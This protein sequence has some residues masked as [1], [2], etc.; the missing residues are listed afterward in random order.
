M[1]RGFEKNR[2]ILLSVGVDFVPTSGRLCT[3]ETSR[4]RH[5]HPTTRIESRQMLQQPIMCSASNPIS[6]DTSH[7]LAN[8]ASSSNQDSHGD[9]ENSHENGGKRSS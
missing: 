9:G 6:H 3:A 8:G 1:P 2:P 4:T 5:A 7:T